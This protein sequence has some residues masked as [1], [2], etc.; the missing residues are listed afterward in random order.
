MP[1]P[2]TPRFW[3]EMKTRR[4]FGASWPRYRYSRPSQF[5]QPSNRLLNGRLKKLRCGDRRGEDPAAWKGYPGL[6]HGRGEDRP[7][8]AANVVLSVVGYNLRLVL[9]WLRIILRVILCF[10]RQDAA[11]QSL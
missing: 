10:A 11:R 9:A 5:D 6:V 1:R 4:G 2:K 8:G 3:P 7:K